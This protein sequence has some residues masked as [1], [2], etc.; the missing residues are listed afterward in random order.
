MNNDRIHAAAKAKERQVAQEALKAEMSE[1]VTS[2]KDE[3]EV[4]EDKDKAK[5]AKGIAKQK[6]KEAKRKLRHAHTP[7][8]AEQA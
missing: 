2:P 6:E 1:P 8:E 7:E 4:A 3:V 5:Q